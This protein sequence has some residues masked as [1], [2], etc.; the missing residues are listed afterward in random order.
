MKTLTAV[1]GAVALVMVCSAGA[2]AEITKNY[3]DV[4]L[5]AS[6]E[7]DHFDD[8]WDLTKGD[9]TLTYGVDLSA[10]T[11]T[12]AG[13]TP[14]IEVGLREVG[15]ADFNP[16]PWDTYQGGAGGW[17]TSQVQDLATEP[18]NL[19]LDDK[20]NLSASGGR[21]EGDYDVYASTPTTVE[22]PT[23]GSSDSHGF[24][25]D[26]D[27]VDPYQDTDIA[28]TGG[29]YD[30]TIVYRAIDSGLGTMIA[31]INGN[32]T[33]DVIQ[34]FRVSGDT[35]TGSTGLSFK[36]DM[37]QMQVFTGGWWTSGAGGDVELTD[38]TATGV[39]EPATMGLLALGGLALIRR[40]RTA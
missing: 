20:H 19:D 22:S 4:T 27:G 26:R 35:Y 17:M 24:W 36:G 30:I 12:S 33:D 5:N 3:G 39:P 21:G 31:T 7:A 10:V 8:V 18:D 40:R 34:E 2:Q 15:A 29:T 13:E 1:I 32:G 16:G 11:Q 14:Y 37:T 25:Y 28:N 38:I 6:Y 9:L 23:F